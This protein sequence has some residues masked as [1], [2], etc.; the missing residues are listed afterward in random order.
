M[1]ITEPVARLLVVEDDENLRVVLTDNLLERGYQVETAATV[2]SAQVLLA[3]APF[4][5]IVLDLMLPDGDGYSL[6]RWYRSTGGAAKVLMLTARTLED[7]IVRGF[8]AGANDYVAKPYRL[9]ELLARVAALVRRGSSAEALTFSGFTLD[10][11]GRVV[12]GAAG[13]IELTRTEFDLLACLLRNR[14]RALTRDQILDT[15]W[16][17]EIVVDTRTVDNFILSLRRKLGWTEAS[18]FRFRAI[19]GVGYRMEV[20]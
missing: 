11:V 7:D 8:E 18:G 12:R 6:C 4:D 14:D 17:A 19:R 3:G 20:D 10:P 9:R 13:Q 15:V 1:P 2:A 16:G 5:L